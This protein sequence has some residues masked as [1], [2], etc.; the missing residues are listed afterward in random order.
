MFILN[1]SNIWSFSFFFTLTYVTLFMSLIIYLLPIFVSSYNL[2]SSTKLKNNFY[3]ISGSEVTMLLA[4]PLFCVYLLNFC[5]MSSD[6]TL[7][8]GH[9]VF[10]N[11]QSK[12]TYL[13][14]FVFYIVL[15]FISS[16]TYFSANEIYDFII[17]QFNFLY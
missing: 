4:T 15:Y 1:V 17:T 8:F 9:L 11:F 7:W 5:W 12:V 2:N 6:L 13:V 3:I 16:V 10:T 14:F